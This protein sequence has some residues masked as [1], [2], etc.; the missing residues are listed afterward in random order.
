MKKISKFDFS[1]FIGGYDYFAVSKQRFNEKEAIEIYIK[2]NF[3]KS[4]E[5]EIGIC[6]AFVRHRAGVN[7]DGE[8]SVGW[9]IEYREEKRSCPVFAFHVVIKNQKH[10]QEYRYFNIYKG[11]ATE[12]RVKHG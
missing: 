6:D 8:P 2:E 5:I 4:D 10:R 11:I 7:E 1:G 9:W 3:C 12:R